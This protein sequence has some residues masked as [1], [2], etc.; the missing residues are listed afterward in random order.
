MGENG[1]SKEI[2]LCTLAECNMRDCS[3]ET[4]ICK[5]KRF[6][7][8]WRKVEGVTGN[9]AYSVNLIKVLCLCYADIHVWP[10]DD[11]GTAGEEA[12]L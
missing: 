6:A 10:R 3:S 9:S 11:S 8:V 4:E 1:V 5:N 12:G 2:V 7:S